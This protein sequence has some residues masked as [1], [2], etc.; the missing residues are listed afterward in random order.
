MAQTAEN[1]TYDTLITSTGNKYM[2]TVVDNIGRANALFW[3][4][5][6]GGFKRKQKGGERIEIPLRMTKSTSGG[7]YEGYDLLNTNPSDPLTKA[8]FPWRQMHYSVILSRLEEVKNSSGATQLIN[9]LQALF[10]DAE[11]AMTQDITDAM[12]GTPYDDSKQCD[13]LELLV[14]E[15][16]TSATAGR[17]KDGK[18]GAVDQSVE[19][20]WRNKTQGNGGTAFEWVADMDSGIAPTGWTA[21]ENLYQNCSK[22]GGSRGKRE[23]NIGISNQLF[24]QNYLSGLAPQRRFVNSKMANAGFRNIMY[25]DLPI[26]WDESMTTASSPTGLLSALY[27]LNSYFMH[28]VVESSTDFYK[29]PFVRPAN[30]DARIAQILLYGNLTVSARFKHGVLVDDNI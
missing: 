8:W 13:G 7:W 23:P 11:D 3:K 5:N 12:F 20:W 21:L 15:D 30:Q 10:D 2:T 28:W 4:L 26:T 14:P 27:M 25:N 16:P 6:Q 24:Y 18:V 22:G 29:T 1:R 9:M 17:D 19:T